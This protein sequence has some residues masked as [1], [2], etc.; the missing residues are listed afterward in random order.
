MNNHACQTYDN[1]HPVGIITDLNNDYHV[2]TDRTYKHAHQNHQ[3]A[4]QDYFRSTVFLSQFTV[5]MN[6]FTGSDFG[7]KIIE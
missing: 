4:H 6:T 5:I 1:D 2:C 7:L 3:H